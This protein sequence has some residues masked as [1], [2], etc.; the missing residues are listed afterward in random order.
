MPVRRV[1]RRYLRFR[2]ASD[3]R[4]RAEEVADAVRRGVLGLYGVH[5]LS[6]IEPVLVE[7]DEG[8]QTGVL[9]C[10]HLHLR[11]MRAALAYVTGIGGTAAS[12]HVTRVSGTLKALRSASTPNKAS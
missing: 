4:H 8:E 12:I 9:R 2:V 3:R 6:Q 7:F 1:R 11:R 10:S 5:G